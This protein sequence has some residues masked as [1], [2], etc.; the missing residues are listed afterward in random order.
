MANVEKGLFD[1]TV[2]AFF[3]P[4]ENTLTLYDSGNSKQTKGAFETSAISYSAS[5]LKRF[6]NKGIGQ[7][8]TMQYGYRYSTGKTTSYKWKDASK[9]G[10]LSRNQGLLV[11]P[12]VHR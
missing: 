8:A 4:Q 5:L 6:A 9:S 7:T 11:P 12:L 1:R 3:Y 2:H 10:V